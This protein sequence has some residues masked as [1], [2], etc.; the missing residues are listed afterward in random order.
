MGFKYRHGAKVGKEE[1]SGKWE[2]KRRRNVLCYGRSTAEQKPA[3]FMAMMRKKIFFAS[4]RKNIVFSAHPQD[5]KLELE[6][7][8]ASLWKRFSP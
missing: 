2:E 4:F 1:G 8:I 6:S 3:A 5:C 7:A